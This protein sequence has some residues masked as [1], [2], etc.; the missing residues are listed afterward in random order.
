MNFYNEKL[1]ND[2]KVCIG[3]IDSYIES[4]CGYWGD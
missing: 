2:F 4:G 1:Y 3:D